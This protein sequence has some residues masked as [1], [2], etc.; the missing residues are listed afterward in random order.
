[1]NLVCG[2]PKGKIYQFWEEHFKDNA[3]KLNVDPVDRKGLTYEMLRY[4]ADNRT[5]PIFYKELEKRFNLSYE[6]VKK[7]VYQ[8]I[9][10][11]LVNKGRSVEEVVGLQDEVL[12]F[13]LRWI[14]YPLGEGEVTEKEIMEE[15]SQM[16]D[17]K[18][19]GIKTTVDDKIERLKEIYERRCYCRGI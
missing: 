4:I 5:R 14:Y 11:D 9:R 2:H 8:L 15:I 19:K 16:L 1:M 13:T 10:A 6:E 12:S 3:E 7:K 18:L 17:A